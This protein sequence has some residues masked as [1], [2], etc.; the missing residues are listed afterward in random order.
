MA[1]AERHYPRLSVI[2]A[3]IIHD[4]SRYVMFPERR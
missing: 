4:G 1:P 3:D 2:D